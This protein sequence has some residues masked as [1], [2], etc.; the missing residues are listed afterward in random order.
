MLPVGGALEDLKITCQLIVNYRMKSL[1]TPITSTRAFSRSS[2][3][4]QA[5]TVAT[6]HLSRVSLM[7]TLEERTAVELNRQST[8]N[9]FLK[10]HGQLQLVMVLKLI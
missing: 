3:P 10:R 1:F 7:A 9:D 2:W 4:L 8:R 5:F 6:C